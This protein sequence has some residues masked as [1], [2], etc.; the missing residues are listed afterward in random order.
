MTLS[1][2]PHG[3]CTWYKPKSTPFAIQLRPP[4]APST[5][6]SNTPRKN[7]SSAE[8]AVSEED[9]LPVRPEHLLH[10]VPNLVER[11]TCPRTIEDERNQVRVRG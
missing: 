6:G 8:V 7:S 3:C 11:G 2:M 4:N 10:R 1:V 9:R 5:F